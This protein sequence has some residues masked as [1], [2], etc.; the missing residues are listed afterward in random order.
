MRSRSFSIVFHNVK[1]DCKQSITNSFSDAKKFVCALEPYPEQSGHHIHVFVEYPNQRFQKAMLKKCQAIVPSIIAPKP[2]AEERSWGRVQVDV[3]RGTFAQAT[4]YL[5]NP[6]KDKICDDDVT[7]KN[8][9]QERKL[10]SQFQEFMR[11]GDYLDQVQFFPDTGR[12][13][14]IE[15]YLKDPR[16]DPSP[17]YIQAMERYNFLCAKY[18]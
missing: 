10:D 11:L 13:H 12:F 9:E 16:A 17:I 4:A 7:T 2:P 8:P 14:T 3:M 6:K 5:T 15:N 1:D 18:T